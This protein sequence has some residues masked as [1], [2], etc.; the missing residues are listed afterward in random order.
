MV[1][2]GGWSEGPSPRLEWAGPHVARAQGHA[3][4]GEGGRAEPFGAPLTREG[5]VQSP[6][7]VLR[8]DGGGVG[9]GQRGLGR[10]WPEEGALRLHGKGCAL[11][12]C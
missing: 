2:S 12:G 9:G 11:S 10:G 4:A 8:G 3:A 7:R 5:L 6:G 1:N